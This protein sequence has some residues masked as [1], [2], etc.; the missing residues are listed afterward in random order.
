MGILKYDEENIRKVLT[1]DAFP[2]RNL[3]KKSELKYTKYYVNT[4]SLIFTLFELE[5]LNVII[6]DKTRPNLI[7][8]YLCPY[9]IIW[10]NKYS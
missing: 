2:K 3:I 8:H 7:Y 4:G 5:L 9:T 10:S 6:L 1:K